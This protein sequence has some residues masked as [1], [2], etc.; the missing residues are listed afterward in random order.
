MFGNSKDYKAQVEKLED[1]V[2]DLERGMAGEERL[3]GERPG[4]A[5]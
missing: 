2:E 4:G 3:C 5:R 1:E